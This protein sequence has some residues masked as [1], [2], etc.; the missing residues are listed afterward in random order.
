MRCACHLR[1][2]CGE[3][4]GHGNPSLRAGQR[5]DLPAHAIEREPHDILGPATSITRG[6]AKRQFYTSSHLL[7]VEAQ[8]CA[9]GKR[10][11]N[12]A[13]VTGKQRTPLTWRTIRVGAMSLDGE[14]APTVLGRDDER[15][16]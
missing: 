11:D 3:R 1:G 4:F 16:T 13:C 14:A 8:R 12:E 10:V 15:L 9:S 7:L 6:H 5:I 2:A